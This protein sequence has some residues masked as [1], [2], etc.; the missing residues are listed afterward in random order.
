MKLSQRIANLSPYPFAE[1]EGIVESLREKGV[2]PI[3]FG[4]GDPVDPTPK[5]IREATKKAI[6]DFAAAGYPSYIGSE[7]FRETIAAWFEK[8]FEIRLN[9]ATEVTSSI[10]GKEA[11]FN[12]PLAFIDAGDVVLIPTPG[13]PPYARGTEFAGGEPYFLPLLPENNFLPDLEKIPAEIAKRA[14]ILWLN[15]PNSPTGRNA[16]DEF[17]EKA[18]KFC[19][20]NEI[21]LASDLAYSE[22]YFDAKP[23]S[24]LQFARKNVVE[25]HSLSKRSR[26]TGYRVGFVVGDSEIVD[27]FK[28]VKTNIDSGTPNFLQA[29]AIA[30]FADEKHVTDS[31]E[32]YREKRDILISALEAV[33]LEKA[34][35]EATFYVWQKV[36][37]GM[38]SEDFAKKLLAPEIAVVATPGSWIS[39]ETAEGLNPG[40]GFV[41]FAL[42]PT[43]EQV[44]E[45]ADRIRNNLKI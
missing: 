43:V 26:M 19:E 33:G 24:I 3:D 28:K 11:V 29:A 44:R 9:P 45:A 35:S 4:V 22:I 42:V 38:S 18:V 14:K 30:A 6:D 8:R 37:D 5:F 32:E 2:E 27:A 20:T 31:I 34:Q 7:D 39:D 25:F 15:Y 23:K 1:L 40:E 41:R 12:F 16:P 17:F 10:G 21:I 36:P 13:Y